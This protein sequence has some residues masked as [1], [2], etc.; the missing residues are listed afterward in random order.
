MHLTTNHK[1]PI[2]DSIFFWCSNKTRYKIYINIYLCVYRCPLPPT[3]PNPTKNSNPN[4]NCTHTHTHKSNII[5]SRWNF[6][7]SRAFALSY[8]YNQITKQNPK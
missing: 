3:P 7:E 1:K 5:E 2:L 4:S 6:C 8:I